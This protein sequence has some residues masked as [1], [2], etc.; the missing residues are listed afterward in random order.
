MMAISFKSLLFFL[1]KYLELN[2]DKSLIPLIGR[3]GFVGGVNRKGNFTELIKGTAF[4]CLSINSRQS[5]LK[6]N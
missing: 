3:G 1:E 2:A 5:L 4:L 6:G